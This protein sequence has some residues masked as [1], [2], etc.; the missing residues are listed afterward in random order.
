[1]KQRNFSILNERLKVLRHVFF[2]L[3]S[4]NKIGI[5]LLSQKW[6][7][8]SRKVNSKDGNQSKVTMKN[9]LKEFL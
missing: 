7:P 4:I 2:N 6:F 1:M 9:K 8:D 5:E 3:M